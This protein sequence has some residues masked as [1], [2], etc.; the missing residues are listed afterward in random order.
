MARQAEA[1]GDLGRT[2]NCKK[3]IL[4]SCKSMQACCKHF[5]ELSTFFL[6]AVAVRLPSLLDN[7]YAYLFNM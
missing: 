1:I 7:D 2:L 3:L 6:V 4:V 5:V